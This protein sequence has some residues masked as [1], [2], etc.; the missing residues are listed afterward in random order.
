MKCLVLQPDVSNNKSVIVKPL[1]EIQPINP[2]KPKPELSRFIED[3]IGYYMVIPSEIRIRT[4]LESD[5]VFVNEV[6]P[7]NT[8]PHRQEQD[9]SQDEQRPPRVN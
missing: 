5:K 1:N 7:C 3:F 4:K 8:K 9:P 6:N 2:F